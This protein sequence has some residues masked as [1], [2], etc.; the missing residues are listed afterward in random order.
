MVSIPSKLAHPNLDEN[1]IPDDSGKYPANVNRDPQPYVEVLQGD[2]AYADAVTQAQARLAQ[3]HAGHRYDFCAD[4][5]DIVDPYISDQVNRGVPVQLDTKDTYDPKDPTK[6]LMPDLGT[7]IRPDWIVTDT[8]DPPGDWY[9][10]R[11]D[12]QDAVVSP[13]GFEHANLPPAG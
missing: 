3:Y 2:P 5:S 6:L 9:P 8:T 7:P 1:A 12:W 10:R 4:T 13:E 11:P